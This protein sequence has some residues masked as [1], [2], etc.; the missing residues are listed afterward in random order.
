MLNEMEL[1]P[2]REVDSKSIWEVNEQGL[3]GTGKV[4]EEGIISLLE[5]AELAIGAFKGDALLGF[6]ICLPPGTEY[7]SLNYA[8]FN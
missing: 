5:F 4:S 6:V 3:P 2:L 7:D 1:R 8:W